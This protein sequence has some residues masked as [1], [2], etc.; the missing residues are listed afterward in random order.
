M[1]GWPLLTAKL[2]SLQIIPGEKPQ[3]QDQHGQGGA[4]GNDGTSA[5]LLQSLQSPLSPFIK[6]HQGNSVDE[7]RNIA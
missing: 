3:L 2:I 6:T 7:I 5:T 1:Q 4:Q